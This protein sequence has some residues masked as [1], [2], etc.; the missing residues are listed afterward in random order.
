MRHS[1]V[2]KYP[3]S[4][5]SLAKWIIEHMP[6]HHSYLEPFFGSGAVLFN[7]NPS[8]IET[9]NDLDSNVYSLFKLIREQPEKLSSIVAATPYSREEYDRTFC[10]ADTDCSLEKVRR[11]LV[12]C[13][14]GHGFRT[15]GYK[16][17]WKND[18]QGRE[19]AYALHNW[20]RLPRWIM[21]TTDRLRHVQIEN[22]AAIDLIQRFSYSNVLIYA[23]PPYVLNTRTG[24]QY[25][26]EMTDQ[27]HIELLEALDKHPG[28]VL[29]SGYACSLYDDRLPHWTRK[30]TRANAEGGRERQE[31]LW[32]NPVAAENATTIPLFGAGD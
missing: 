32:L 11:F 16:N 6:T 31:V 14:Q 9:V 5:W 8:P 3:G 21:E 24:K 1:P 25:K 22:M 4:K 20:H 26:H 17:G 7:K 15:N 18:V 13:W 30:T 29:L 19:K 2:L 23:D 12:Q 10:D 27:D 28:P